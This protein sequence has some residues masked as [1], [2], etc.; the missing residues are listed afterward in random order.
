[1]FNSNE[2]LTEL[3]LNEYQRY[4][5]QLLLPQIQSA[6]QHRMRQAKILCIGAG[7]LGSASIPY[8]TAAGIGHIT[9]IDYDIVEISNL[10]RQ[11]IHNTSYLYQSKVSSTFNYIR[12]LN[13]YCE[14]KTLQL[15]L[16]QDNIKKI[17]SRY[18]LIIDGT[19]NIETRY[20]IDETCKLLGKPWIYGAVFQFT[21]QLSVFNYKGGPCY[22]DIYSKYN[23]TDTMWSCS[24][25]GI[26]GVIPG[27]I[28]VLQA[29]EAL[30]I[31]LGIGSIL[32]GHLLIFDSLNFTIKKIKIRQNLSFESNKKKQ[33]ESVKNLQT[34]YIDELS[35][36][37]KNENYVFID[38]RSTNEYLME[39][40]P[41]AINY[42]LNKIK[43]SHSLD[44]IAKLNKTKIIYCSLDSRS[45]LAQQMLDT[46]NISSIRLE[47]GL[48]T[49]KILKNNATFKRRERDSNPC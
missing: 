12:K 14:I 32:S 41:G 38:V 48:K 8:L 1:M 5:R 47:H 9:V 36:L 25:G 24:E 4:S 19:D 16:K 28:G 49:W 11:I 18:D 21:G 45:K 20:L 43:Y 17:I 2:N 10:Q 22:K 40:I 33:T 30:K 31:I 26:L 6:G 15:E 34:I 23:S 44:E 29:T 39:K 7:A 42:P 46:A 35:N 3:S 27:I 37:L 13:P